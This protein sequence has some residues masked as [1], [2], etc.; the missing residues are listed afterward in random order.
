MSTVSLAKC[1]GEAVAFP[2]RG[3]SQAGRQLQ[4]R[5]ERQL[6]LSPVTSRLRSSA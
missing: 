3:V 6:K 5:R 2:I 1:L 4:H